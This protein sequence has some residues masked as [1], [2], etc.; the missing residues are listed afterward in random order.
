MNPLIITVSQ[1]NR[2]A[3]ALIAEDKHLS[4]LF[5]KGELSNVTAHY[6]SGHL[7]FTLK[8]ENSAVKC[9]M[10]RGSASVLKFRPQDG[11]SVICQARADL[12]ERDGRFQLY[13]NDIQ[14]DGIGA[15]ALGFQQT[16]EK[17]EAEGLFRPELKRPIPQLPKRVAVVTSDTGAAV[18]D[19]IQILGRRNPLVEILLCPV[20]VQGKDGVA[21]MLSMLERL[22]RR[23]DMDIIIIGRGGGSAEDLACFNDEEFARM[24]RR[25]PVPVISA[26]G[27]ETDYTICDFVADLRAPTPS[28]AAEL[29]AADIVSLRVMTDNLSTRLIEAYR[30][31]V[32]QKRTEFEQL[33]ARHDLLSRDTLSGFANRVKEIT[34]RLLPAYRDRLSAAQTALGLLAGKLDALSPLSTLARGYA[35]VYKAGMLVCSTAQIA[36]GE[37]ISVRLRDGK[38]NAVVEEAE[39]T[40]GEINHDL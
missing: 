39:A 16:K 4:G 6:A 40:K 2:Y 34:N 10:F 25:S 20:L 1:L 28:A 9:V 37:K 19:I 8:D 12:W 26:V 22:Y 29:V 15:L 17:L 27:H 7:Y 13:V 5:V 33:S 38:L 3:H 32:A 31:I 18:Q 35:A 36:A 21:S 14:P 23:K 11:M 30:E 24:V